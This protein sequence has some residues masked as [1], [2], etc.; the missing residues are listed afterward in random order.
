LPRH[1][2][3]GLVAAALVATPGLVATS[4]DAMPA[5]GP[6][7]PCVS[8]ATAPAPAFRRLPDTPKVSAKT[9]AAVERT[10]AAAQAPVVAPGARSAE[11]AALP[12]FR[13]KVQIHIIHGKHRREHK[14]KRKAA[15][16]LFR[17]LRDGYNGAQW[18][19][20][21]EPMGIVFKL[22]GITVS[23][24]DRWYHAGPR[25]RAGKQMKRRLH[26][27]T[28]RT[29]NIYLKS[30]PSVGGGMLLGYAQFPWYY[31]GKRKK[32][33]GVEV[34]VAGMP[35][36]SA[37][38]YN[39]GD[40]VIHETGHWLGLLHTFQGGCSGSGDKVDDTPAE[41]E[42]TFTCSAGITPTESHVCDPVQMVAK[43]YYD[44]ALNFLDYSYDG[45]MRMFTEGQHRLV[46]AMWTRYR[47][48]R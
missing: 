42:P 25:S 40:T 26:R 13:V 20:V 41:S 3:L 38:G 37:R 2:L 16:R 19:G 14:V 30:F 18:P 1:A 33:D 15:R 22:K 39:L 10:V 28:S 32:L 6:V 45:C 23:K 29:L 17:I 4:A 31:H 21:S 5:P 24:N 27:G 8:G 12:V 46:S 47:A 35:G 7:S 48:G 44:P 36:G 34:N 43:G 9:L 11:P